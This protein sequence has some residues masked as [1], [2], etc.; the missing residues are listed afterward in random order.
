LKERFK[1]LIV[2]EENLKIEDLAKKR[3]RVVS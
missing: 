1:I 2:T 3:R